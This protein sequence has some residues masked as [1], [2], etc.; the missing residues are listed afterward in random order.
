MPSGRGLLRAVV[1]GVVLA[2]AAHADGFAIPT[3]WREV[4]VVAGVRVWAADAPGGFW[5]RAEGRVAAP[6]ASIFRRLSDFDA[7]PRLYPWLADIRVLDRGP[8]TALVY[9]RYDLPWPLA[10]RDYVAQHHWRTEPSGTIVFSA[11][12]DGRRIA[13]GGDTV[14][15]EGLIVQMTFAPIER[16]RATDVVYL[17]RSDLGGALPRSVRATTAWKIPMNAILAM[18]RSLEPLYAPGNAR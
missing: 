8:D 5:G 9:F 2:G 1:A 13:A 4:E 6:A 7:L 11:E 10:D 16:G 15:V 17:F 12:S 14:P 3:D 18:R